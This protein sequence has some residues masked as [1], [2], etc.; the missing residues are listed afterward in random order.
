M[1]T[2]SGSSVSLWLIQDSLNIDE[3]H[4]S[5]RSLRL[6]RQKVM[7]SK[8]LMLAAAAAV[9][10]PSISRGQDLPSA[11]EVVERSIK[12]SGGREAFSKIKNVTMEGKFTIPEANAEG[13]M[14]MVFGLPNKAYIKVDL[15]GLGSQ[16]QGLNDK[17]AWEM[18]AQGNRRMS[19]EEHK[20]MMET[21]NLYST[22]DPGKIYGSMENKG[23]EEVNGEKCYMLEMKRKDNDQVDKFYYSVKTGLVMRSL[24]K[25]P[26]PFGE[27]E[28]ET[29]LSDYTTINGIKS[30]GKMSHK[31]VNLG[32]TQILE[33]NSIKYNQEI[34]DSKFAVPDAIKNLDK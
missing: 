14:E 6:E 16:E 20:R 19:D 21:V 4:A 17:M 23:V 32:M 1:N 25:E 29:T 18:S 24:S 31:L 7:K 5:R 8:M 33:F 10:I 9:M 3:Y 15:G 22:F 30:P 12:E 2:N 34:D 27:I 28:V 13:K 26:S 11:K